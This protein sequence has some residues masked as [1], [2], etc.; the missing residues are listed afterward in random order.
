MRDENSATDPP[1]EALQPD[2]AALR[3]GTPGCRQVIRFHNAGCGMPDL[4]MTDAMVGPLGL[5]ARIGGY[6]APAARVAEDP[7]LHTEIAVLIDTTPDNDLVGACQSVGQFVID[8]EEIG[9]DLRTATRREFPRGSG[10]RYVSDRVL[11]AGHEPPLTGMH[12][13]RRTEPGG[14]E[15]VGAAGRFEE[16]EFP[17]ATVLGSAAATRYARRVGI[18]AVE[19]RTPARAARLRG[20][21]E[22]IPG[23][24]V[25]DRD[26]RLAALVTF[27]VA[28]RQPQPFK[29]AMDTRGI[30]S[31][32]ERGEFARFDFGDES[33]EGCLRSSP[34]Y[35]TE[36]QVDHVAD[37]V[38]DLAGRGR[39]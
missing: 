29:A 14:Y 39:R 10:F 36:E 2:V 38:A 20:R 19:Q 25:L 18:Q 9:C 12:G 16:R 15:P 26:P 34:H 11:R 32:L 3:A 31:A 23:V 24:S 7:E 21:L 22:R 35:D 27:G 4:P 1:R 17:Y 28:G 33:A 37:A 8:V 30:N 13:A 6:E 5:E